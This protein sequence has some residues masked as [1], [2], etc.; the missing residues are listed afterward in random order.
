MKFQLVKCFTLQTHVAQVLIYVVP[1]CTFHIGY[2]TDPGVMLPP[3][4][5]LP[6]TVSWIYAKSW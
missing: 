1:H 5:T 6:V 2:K 4:A 3:R